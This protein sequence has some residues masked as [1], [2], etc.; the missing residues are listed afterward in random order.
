[1]TGRVRFTELLGGKINYKDFLTG[2]KNTN[3][4]ELIEMYKFL[5][6]AMNTELTEK[7]SRCLTLFLIDGKPQKEIARLLGVNASTVNR[8]IAA[9]KKKLV[10]TCANYGGFQ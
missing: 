1:M 10:R 2:S 9:A 7:Q 3:I 4:N 8:H 5:R 6:K